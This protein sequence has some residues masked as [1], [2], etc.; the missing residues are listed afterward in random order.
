MVLDDDAVVVSRTWLKSILD[1]LDR[2]EAHSNRKL[3]CITMQPSLHIIAIHRASLHLM[4][5][6]SSTRND[7]HSGSEMVGL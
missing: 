1:S 3:R 6:L 7:R 4:P 5:C 2:A